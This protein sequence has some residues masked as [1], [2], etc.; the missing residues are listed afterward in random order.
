MSHPS[1]LITC[2]G[3]IL[4]LSAPFA[5]ATSEGDAVRSYRD[6]DFEAAAQEWARLAEQPQ[7]SRAAQLRAIEGKAEALR[8][9][10]MYPQAIAALKE[11]LALTQELH[12]EAS[13]AS[14]LG[15]LGNILQ[16]GG[17]PAEAE[18]ALHTSLEL[19]A[20]LGRHD[21]LAATY[22]NLGNLRAFQE[23]RRAALEAYRLGADQARQAG[24]PELQ[25]RALSNAAH[26]AGPAGDS[27]TASALAEQAHG[28]AR[29]LPDSHD[30]AYLLISLGQFYAALPASGSSLQHA[31]Q[32]LIESLAVADAIADARAR[33]YAQGYLAQLYQRR[34]RAAEAMEL[35]RR[36]IAAIQGRN[37]PEI[38]YRWY[39]QQ[40]GLKKTGGD[41]AGA[42]ADYRLAVY[43]L[44]A[45]RSD[46]PVVGVSGKS[47]FREVLGPL[48]FELAD[49]LLQQAGATAEHDQKQALLRE[50]RRTI[51]LSKAAELQDYFQDRCV[52]AQQGR[53]AGN[54]TVGPE[55]AVIYPILL[56][57][58]VELL[59]DFSDG[60]EEV[61]VPVGS[62][63]LVETVR[64]FRAKLEKRTTREYLPFGRQLYD[65]LIRPLQATLSAHHSKTLVFVP[66][67]ALRTIP[68][69]ALS[70]GNHF[71][72]ERYA[73][74]TTPSLA[75]TDLKE[76]P[77]AKIQRALL[78]GLTQ[79]VQG[80]SALPN[81]GAEL[82]AVGRIYGGKTLQDREYVVN[83]IEEELE[84]T[85]Y[86]VV[87]IA[88]HGQFQSDVR[89]TFLLAYD[90]KL[91]MD[92]LEKLISP[93][94]FHDQ[95]ISLL[96]LSACQTAAGDDRA[97]LGLAGVAVKAGARSALASLWFIN[98]QSATLLVTAFYEAL[99]QPGMSKA[100]ALQQAQ[101]KLIAD[102]RYSHPG[103]W[104]PFLLIG[105]W[106]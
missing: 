2:T 56:P 25:A 5:A 52:A 42:I 1:R 46:L 27:N 101:L 73:I 20:K 22:T 106:L 16:V 41:R 58:R 4:M 87:H 39:W 64:E 85:P 78:N 75:L 71:L 94:R 6:G 13:R 102:K 19:A 105:S 53:L 37:A 62:A 82:Q 83:R 70:D 103:Y 50:A 80:F 29:G 17:N 97:A 66:D 55:V 35:N 72:I 54:A 24:K 34:G 12:D 43:H 31:H 23:R 79:A 10:G 88:S 38:V 65:W 67:G 84:E 91:N 96:T 99:H 8:A 9:L 51:E 76:A 68:M 86:N 11:A 98:D 15:S 92:E 89:Q 104:S 90:G 26:V 81:V 18:Q 61:Q 48:Y 30:K 21:I 59:V 95:P 44:Q 69:A 33:S 60:I 14:L 47:S 63:Q 32:A 100:A 93:S 74:A 3:L 57:D 45:I 77:P 36:A 40:G 7:G 49:L 28:I